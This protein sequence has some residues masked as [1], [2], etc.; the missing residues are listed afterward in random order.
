MRRGYKD[1]NARTK[2]EGQQYEDT[3]KYDD[4]DTRTQILGHIY[5]NTVTRM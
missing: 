2:I 3:D 1:T 5:K 4:I